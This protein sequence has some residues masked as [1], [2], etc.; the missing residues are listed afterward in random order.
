MRGERAL[1]AMTFRNRDLCCSGDGGSLV[2]RGLG[3]LPVR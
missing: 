2:L 3:V 1:D